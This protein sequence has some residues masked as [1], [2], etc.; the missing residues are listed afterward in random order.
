[1]DSKE[2]AAYDILYRELDKILVDLSNDMKC[3]LKVKDSFALTTDFEKALI[4]S[5]N[6]YLKPQH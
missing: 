6:R 5:S 1:M 3:Q 2:E 4:N